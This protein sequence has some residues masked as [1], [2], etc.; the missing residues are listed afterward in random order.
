VR[1][2]PGVA[3]IRAYPPESKKVR[4]L[5]AKAVYLQHPINIQ[6]HRNKSLNNLSLLTQ[7]GS[8]SPERRGLGRVVIGEFDLVH[9][10]G[11]RLSLKCGTP[12]WVSEDAETKGIARYD[13]DFYSLEMLRAWPEKK[14]AYGHDKRK[15]SDDNDEACWTTNIL[16]HVKERLV[17]RDTTQPTPDPMDTSW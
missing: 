2:V 3:T 6:P 9:R 10:E 17:N 16:E 12:G 8:V 1:H 11:T 14:T 15:P 4:R 5:I 7:Q 13:I